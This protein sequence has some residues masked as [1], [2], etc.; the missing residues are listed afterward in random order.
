MQEETGTTNSNTNSGSHNGSVAACVND[1]VS[2]ESVT[3]HTPDLLE[4]GTDA[5]SDVRIKGQ[6][7]V[8][9]DDTQPAGVERTLS[10]V[11]RTSRS[12]STSD[13]YSVPTRCASCRLRPS[14]TSGSSPG[15]GRRNRIEARSEQSARE[16]VLRDSRTRDG[17][18]STSRL[19]QS[20]IKESSLEDHINTHEENELPR[21]R[22]NYK[23][24]VHK[25]LW[26]EGFELTFTSCT[27][28]PLLI[29]IRK[30]IAC[31]D[32]TKEDWDSRTTSAGTSQECM[33]GSQQTSTSRT[34][35]KSVSSADGISSDILDKPGQSLCTSTGI[36][37][38]N[39][40]GVSLNAAASD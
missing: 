29:L 20:I 3:F 6:F 23:C 5:S 8:C 40:V 18:S 12:M 2:R 15:T 33:L 4:K 35:P 19:S 31:E 7:N 9:K 16:G 17:S 36:V 30:N 11:C 1:R 21:R 28:F 10:A 24:I 22:E 32:S 39:S 37:K 38:S 14:L 13:G 26:L 25:G 27:I 34:N